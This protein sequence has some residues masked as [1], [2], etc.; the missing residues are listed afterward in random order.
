ME[1]Y[2]LNKKDETAWDDYVLNHPDSTFYHQIGWKNVVEKSYGHK[3]IYLVAKEDNSIKGI[4]ALFLMKSRIFGNKLVSVPFA[5]YG[6]VIADNQKIEKALIEQ[7]KE[8]TDKWNA[9]YLE[10]RQF[11]IKQTE[12]VS[13]NNY[14]TSILN[15]ERNPSIIWNECRKSMRRY[16]RKAVENNLIVIR[17]SKSIEGFYN[18]YSRNMHVLGTPPHNIAFFE[19]IIKEFP[20]H[21]DIVTVKNDNIAIASIFL[22]YFKKSVIYGW[23]GSLKEYS[24]LNPNYILF[25]ETIKYH[26]ENGFNSFDFGRSQMN[27]GV[28][29]FKAGWGA[30][31]KQLCY[32]YY[33][34]S[35][36][37]VDTSQSN[38][39][40]QKFGKIW[41]KIPLSMANILGAKIRRNIP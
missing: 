36:H 15:L 7:A 18:L 21:T 2:T 24:E 28:Y 35:N 37:N 4:L 38:P 1:I 29:L 26:S 41:R 6:G 16:V 9:D 8:I 22:L 12:L 33:L 32:Q 30:Q 3:P 10:L 23:G 13:N 14:Y 39:K 34:R 19:N 5:P 11:D 17:N 27:T 25:W 31:P 40:R 20:E